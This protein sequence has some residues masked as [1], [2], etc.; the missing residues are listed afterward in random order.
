MEIELVYYIVLVSGV[1]QNDS[2]THT[3]IYSFADSFP[4]QVIIRQWT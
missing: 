3:H 4:L 1:Q 2:V